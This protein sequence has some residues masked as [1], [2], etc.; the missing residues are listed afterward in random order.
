MKMSILLI[1]STS[2][3]NTWENSAITVHHGT[4]K[5]KPRGSTKFNGIL[6]SGKCISYKKK[7]RTK[8]INTTSKVFDTTRAR[9]K[10]PWYTASCAVEP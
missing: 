4:F 1:T 3:V 7:E 2:T 5:H 9:L 8:E 6:G 10:T